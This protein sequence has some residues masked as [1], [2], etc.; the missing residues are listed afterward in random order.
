MSN[1]LVSISENMFQLFFTEF[2]QANKHQFNGAVTSKEL[3]LEV[4]YELSETPIIK[5]GGTSTDRLQTLALMQLGADEQATAALLERGGAASNLC[6]Y[7]VSSPMLKAHEQDVTPNFTLELNQVQIIAYQHDEGK[8]GGQIAS[9]TCKIT[10]SG[11]IFIG[12]DQKLYLSSL[13]ADVSGVEGLDK[14]ALIH[15]INRKV[16]PILQEKM[17]GIPLPDCKEILGGRLQTHYDQVDFRDRLVN[18][19]VTVEENRQGGMPPRGLFTP[20]EETILAV[21]VKEEVIRMFMDSNTPFPFRQGM[22]YS[23]PVPLITA[24]FGGFVQ[25]EKPQIFLHDGYAD[26]LLSIQVS[27]KL[28][29]TIIRTH[30]MSIP[31]NI[32]VWFE[33]VPTITSDSKK[34]KPRLHMKP[35][36]SIKSFFPISIPWPFSMVYDAILEQFIALIQPVFTIIDGYVASMDITL[37]EL[38]NKL[39]GT[40]LQ[41]DI[42]FAKVH[43]S[44]GMVLAYVRVMR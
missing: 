41:A 20:S 44:E 28:S 33:V 6:E 17:G 14:L 4:T 35:L 31:V 40:N 29:L 12:P 15:V 21:A 42:R 11:I 16:V 1:L 43:I 27:I 24:A 2:F 7:P 37:F 18:M 23:L 32:P 39:P 19:Y 26:A 25:V 5:L 9:L 10:L 3:H 38:G 13:H 36:P 22:E 8:R 30:T 34:I